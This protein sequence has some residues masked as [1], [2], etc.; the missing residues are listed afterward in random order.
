MVAG[1]HD[2]ADTCLPAGAHRTGH[3][4]SRRVDH[5]GHTHKSHVKFHILIIC[6]Q[7][8]E[9]THG[10]AKHTQSVLRH[11]Q[12]KFRNVFFVS[13]RNG[14][15]ASR[16]Q[17]MCAQRQHF[18]HCTLGIRNPL[19]IHA[20]N[21]GHPLS[22]GIKRLLKKAGIFILQG[23]MVD[24]KCL[25][26]IDQRALCGVTDDFSRSIR[27]KAGV[28]AESRCINQFLIHCRMLFGSAFNRGSSTVF[29]IPVDSN[30]GYRHFIE[31][32]RTGFIGTDDSCAAQRFH[33]GQFSNQSVFLRH[34]LH[35]QRH[36]NRGCGRQ[37]FRD[38][39]NCQRNR[40]QELRNQRALIKSA[41]G[42]NQATD[43]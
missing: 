5:S 10:K 7:F 33:C 3:F 15:H 9:G 13:L 20:V 25:R 32:K 18:I 40:N 21:R 29:K 24:P 38:N 1:N 2:R 35:A 14:P 8:R 31:S 37:A 36:Y 6:G 22:L 26:H 34:A 28:I 42:E 30:V 27:V 23:F 19:P 17:N 39:G 12:A 41:D 11:G 4:F 43:D 16:G